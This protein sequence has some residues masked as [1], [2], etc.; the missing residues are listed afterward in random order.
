MRFQTLKIENGN[1]YNITAGLA[2]GSEIIPQI[3]DL[4]HTRLPHIDFG[5]AHFDR[6]AGVVRLIGTDDELMRTASLGAGH[7]TVIDFFILVIHKKAERDVLQFI[8]ELSSIRAIHISTCN[9]IEMI[10]AD[11]DGQ[12]DIVGMVDDYATDNLQ[13]SETGSEKGLSLR[14]RISGLKHRLVSDFFVNLKIM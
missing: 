8:R 6:T 9:T 3:Q 1:G 5:L 11:N 12:Q 13:P 4:F 7:V 10:I 2:A 14:E